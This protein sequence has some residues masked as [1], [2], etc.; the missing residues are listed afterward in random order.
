M[1]R[2]DD[3]TYYYRPKIYCFGLDSIIYMA[4]LLEKLRRE[5]VTI[6]APL[7]RLLGQVDNMIR[8]IL[9]SGLS[10]SISSINIPYHSLGKPT[11]DPGYIAKMIMDE[12]KT[13]PIIHVPL[14]VE[15]RYSLIGKLIQYSIIGVEGILLLSGD[16]KIGGVSYEEAINLAR[17]FIDGEIAFE[18]KRFKVEKH[19]YT[20]GG[21]LIPYRD[22]EVE[23]VKYKVRIGIQ[24][25]Q[26]QVIL[27]PQHILK[28]LNNGYP[29]DTPLLIGVAPHLE[30]LERY[31]SS[32]IPGYPPRNMPK[33][34]RSYTEWLA[35]NIGIILDR[36]REYGVPAGI[37]I[38]PISWSEASISTAGELL[39]LI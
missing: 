26:T 15:N 2:L 30:S 37:H 23:R 16:V 6:E 33:R 32:H 18:D 7:I 9:E 12:L 10:M 19:V 35:S 38:Y 24:F 11:S 25:F 3:K 29:R 28:I 13:D 14:G 36:C 27:E 8:L 39:D 31:L 17:D 21:A 22:D 20:L 34:Q 1:H 4:D 5:P